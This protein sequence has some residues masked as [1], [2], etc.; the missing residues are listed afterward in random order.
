MPGGD[1]GFQ[2][3][4]ADGGQS[5]GGS[6]VGMV[7]GQRL[8][9]EVEGVLDLPVGELVRAVLLLVQHAEPG[10]VCGGQAGERLMH[11]GQV[12]GPVIGQGE[13]HAQ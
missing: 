11:P 2:Q 10:L 1:A 6:A 13:L 8:R 5:P 7:F 3:A 9:D 12:R 4:V